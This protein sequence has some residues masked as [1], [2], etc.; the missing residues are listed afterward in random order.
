MTKFSD[1]EDLPILGKASAGGY[2]QPKAPNMQSGMASVISVI[3]DDNLRST[4][5]ISCQISL[6]NGELKK[7]I[8]SPVS[9]H[10]FI[11]P[12]PNEKVY[13]FKDPGMDDWYYLGPLTN[14]GLT[15]HTGNA[16]H[17]TYNSE[18]II[19]TGEYFVAHPDSSRCLDVYE[20]DY[21]IQSRFGSTLRMTHTNAKLDTPW[22]TGAR[23]ETTPIVMLRTGYL[24]VESLEYDMASIW[25][26]SD[27]IIDI[28]FQT[29]TP[30]AIT[31]DYENSQIVLYSDRIMI[32]SRTD[33][34]YLSSA[35]TIQLSTQA[36]NHDVDIVL[37]TVSELI[38]QVNALATEISSIALS[39]TTQT[40]TVVSLGPTLP[41]TMI[42]NFTTNYNNA[43]NAQLSIQQIQQKLDALKQ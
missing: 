40:F 26:T 30:Q 5:V 2:P 35:N 15:N 37:D 24:P 12:V 22:N 3:H 16:T 41:S 31:P 27:Q 23:E 13:C 42:G 7:I 38:E 28:P 39:C 1:S 29:N 32:G 33:D 11:C 18:G 17:I 36:W 4:G 25:L 21:V 6:S 34:I 14:Q 10:N 9:T 19:F 8:A 43:L 20:G